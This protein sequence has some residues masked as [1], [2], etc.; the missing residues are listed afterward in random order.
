PGYRQGVDI[1]GD[2]SG[3][4]DPVALTGA[5]A[6]LAAVLA[7]AHCSSAGS[8]VAE[9][10]SCREDAVASLDLSLALRLGAGGRRIALTLDAFNV[11]GSATGVV[12]RAA[13]LVD[14]TGTITTSA[15]GRTVVPMVVNDNFG[16]LLSRRGEPRTLRIGLRVEN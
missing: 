3:G 7:N 14:P 4:N 15:A 9:R 12:D 8:G 2:G 11:V 16:T 6:G 13:L 5:P 10:N 1:N